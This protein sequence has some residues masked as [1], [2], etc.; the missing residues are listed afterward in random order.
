MY[1]P[2]HYKLYSKKVY[3]QA[4][5]DIE[6]KRELREE[7]LFLCFFNS[8]FISCRVLATNGHEN[9]I[10]LTRHVM[11]KVNGTAVTKNSDFLQDKTA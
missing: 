9:D 10:P 7:S 5:T 6:I 1:R 3:F 8:S 2:N 11:K 4:F